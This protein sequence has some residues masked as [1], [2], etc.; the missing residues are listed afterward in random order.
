MQGISRLSDADVDNGWTKCVV[1]GISY[2]V[3]NQINRT[4]S[5]PEQF[6][7]LAAF[8]CQF[9]SGNISYGW[10]WWFGIVYVDD[11]F[12]RVMVTDSATFNYDSGQQQEIQF[13]L[14]WA[15]TQ[16][17]AKLNLG[18]FQTMLGKYLWVIDE[19]DTPI[20][21]GTFGS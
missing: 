20:L 15:D 6:D 17:T 10:H 9:A 1:N 19:N 7:T 12:A 11:S 13:P 21:I 3:K 14:T 2:G 18:A 4:A 5:V 16:I 8:Q